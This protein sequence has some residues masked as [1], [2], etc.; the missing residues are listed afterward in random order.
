MGQVMRA[1]AF[2]LLVA[3][4]RAEADA[5]AYTVGQVAHGLTSGG[6]VTGVDYGHGVVSGVGAIGNRAVYAAAPAVHVAAPAVYTVATP[7]VYSGV[8]SGIHSA[9][10][11]SGLSSIYGN[12]YGHYYGKREAEAEPEAEAEADPLVY[13]TGVHAPVVAS[14]YAHGVVAPAVS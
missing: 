11:Y 10:V 12:H 3:A 14:T 2:V 1:F 7:A 13:T 6:V 9:G 5:D 4:A 8:Y